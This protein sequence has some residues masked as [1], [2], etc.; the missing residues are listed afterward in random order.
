MFASVSGDRGSIPGRI[1]TKTQKMKLDAALLNTQ[2][3]KVRIKGKM[4]Q[5]REGNSVVAIEKGALA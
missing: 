2:Q 3:Y 1:I 5:S 4:E